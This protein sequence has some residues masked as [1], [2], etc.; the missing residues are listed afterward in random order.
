MIF[1]IDASNEVPNTHLNKDMNVEGTDAQIDH[2]EI[3]M[4]S[5][6]KVKTTT[7]RD[8]SVFY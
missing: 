3:D 4:I 1:I 2:E 5:N 8:W 7:L 6:L